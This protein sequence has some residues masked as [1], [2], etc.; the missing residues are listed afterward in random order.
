MPSVLCL[1]ILMTRTT[2]LTQRLQGRVAP[3]HLLLVQ[4]LQVYL[5]EQLRVVTREAGPLESTP[6]LTV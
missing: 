4:P 6:L 3:L 2:Q 5:P 1:L